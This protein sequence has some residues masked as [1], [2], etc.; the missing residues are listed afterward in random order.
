[1]MDNIEERLKEESLYEML[2]M[3]EKETE[4]RKEKIEKIKE[5]IQ[6]GEYNVPVEEVVE[7]LLKFLKERG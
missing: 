7:K 6:K 3:L 1:M 5:L 4:L 2:K